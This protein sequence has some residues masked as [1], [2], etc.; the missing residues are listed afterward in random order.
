MAE[1][2]PD[3][4]PQPGNNFAAYSQ[5]YS[6]NRA[7]GQLLSGFAEAGQTYVKERDNSTRKDIALTANTEVSNVLSSKPIEPVDL[8]PEMKS[9][10]T[11]LENYKTALAQGVMG[12]V[13]FKT[14][15][16]KT[17]KELRRRFGSG[18]GVEIDNALANAQGTSTANQLRT[19]LNS[20]ID[21]YKRASDKT[22]DKKLSFMQNELEII[23][24]GTFQN[25]YQQQ[26][27]QKFT[28]NGDYNYEV[29]AAGVAQLKAEKYQQ[30]R[31][32]A[33]LDLNKSVNSY[34]E[35][36]GV[37]DAQKR[38]DLMSRDIF[39]EST[40]KAYGTYLGAQ[41][42]AMA[43]GTLNAQESV[44]LTQLFSAFKQDALIR[45][46]GVLSSEYSGVITTEAGKAAV[47]SSLTDKLSV[48][49]SALTN[50]D[51]GLITAL[52]RSN[53]YILDDSLGR[54]IKDPDYGEVNSA[55]SAMNKLGFP[56]EIIAQ[57]YLAASVKLPGGGTVTGPQV[58][59][60]LVAKAMFGSLMTNT[61]SIYN[62]ASDYT[63][64]GAS[65]ESIRSSL[66]TQLRSV[67]NPSVSP[68]QASQMVRSLFEGSE[69][70]NFIR[71]F[72][73]KD[74]IGLL[75]LMASPEMTKKLQGTEVW[76]FYAQWV[77]SQFLTIS[78]SARDTILSAKQ[79]G[80]AVDVTFDGDKF[81]LSGFKPSIKTAVTAG[82]LGP[83]VI[84][85]DVL[86]YRNAYKAVSDINSYLNIMKPVAEVDGITISE[87]VQSLFQTED[88]N[89]VK[90]DE[91]S[92]FKKMSDALDKLAKDTAE[93]L[94]DDKKE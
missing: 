78:Q 13:E 15:L 43:D 79:G 89:K 19:E 76:G 10:L 67:L 24:T 6:P 2:N 40:N 23:G 92:V 66:T 81:V 25:F 62:L 35:D 22:Y 41:T 3:I 51:M 72:A 8:P 71:D 45:A 73:K 16:D 74:R 59:Q 83:S 85:Q 77:N 17:A 80:G 20:Q 5:G 30:D 18:W 50:K 60:D 75:S 93:S 82:P 68:E 70:I 21:T 34:N 11:K 36:N 69:N 38:I 27:G 49:E 29:A 87:M 46:Q 48:Y 58:V 32:K 90:P 86:A 57:G 42:A 33:M 12:D 63:K 4:G 26:T 52:A 47:M 14:R 84:A 44:Q 91:N 31:D 61:N 94:R 64:A 1:F 9:S 54:L 56:P 55:V 37:R 65:P 39:N 88:I 28:Y 7:I 53:A